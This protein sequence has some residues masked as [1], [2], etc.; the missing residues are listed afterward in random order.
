[1]EENTTVQTDTEEL[2][3]ETL[4]A[5]DEGW[6]D[7]DEPEI[8]DDGQDAGED[9]SE[10]PETESESE[11]AE[12]DADQQE[13]EG[14]EG[15]D[16]D[17][18][19]EGE[20]QGDEGS[21]DPGESFLLKHLGEEK[22]V[23]KDEVIALAQ[24]G[25]D[26][27]RIREKWDGVK[28]DITKLRM[29]ES[30]LAELAE[31]RG[32][33]IE[34]LIDETRT[35][36]LL[37]RAEAR[38]EELSPAEAAAQAVKKR[39]DFVPVGTMTPEEQRQEKSQRETERFLAAYPKVQATDIPKEVWDAVNENGGDLLGAYRDWE[40]AKLKADIKALKKELGAEKQQKENK[41]RS[42]GSMKSAG[43]SARRD[44]FDEGWDAAY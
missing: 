2:A 1:M 43:S 25:M 39:T 3:A 10:E 33:D 16:A 6:E 29:Y 8:Y 13:A 26:Y 23:S 36:T 20:E 31:A 11:E 32:G 34:S 24:K 21:P 37:A 9:E 7:K 14:D 27:D 4:A 15:G 18:G 40:N 22:S 5:F 19:T 44:A 35:R 28:D 42:T 38:G 30:F 17:E 41:A 12:A